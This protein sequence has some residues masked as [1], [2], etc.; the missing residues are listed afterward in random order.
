VTA[1]ILLDAS[2]ILSW[3]FHEPGA[4]EV[5]RVLTTSYITSVN[6]AEVISKV[7]RLTTD[8]LACAAD[9]VESGLT[10]LPFGWQEMA[11]ISQITLAWQGRG[12]LSLGDACCLATGISQGMEIWT[13]DRSW[14]E[15]AL[16][17]NITL[18]RD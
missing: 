3:L 16:P 17:A 9:L 11:S 2:C 14:V 8:G 1:P 10:V 4:D 6:M 15:L 13:A 7:D 12:H 18:I 5:E